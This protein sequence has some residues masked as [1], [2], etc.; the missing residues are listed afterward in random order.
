MRRREFLGGTVSGAVATAAMVGAG[1]TLVSHLKDPAE[2]GR[3]SYSEQ[4]EDL[5]LFHVVRDILRAETA[6]Y[7]DVGAAYPVKGNNTY[8]LYSAGGEGVLVEPNPALA[9]QLR[10]RRP[11]DQVVEAGVGPGEATEA[12]YFVV[13]GN[14]MLNTF[15]RA[16]V[17]ELGRERGVDAVARVLKMPLVT[18]NR[19]IAERFRAAPD[20]LSTDVEGLDFDILQTL[21]LEHRR[22][23]AICAESAWTTREGAHS[24]IA[25][26][27]IAKGY[28]P[29]GGSLVNTIFVDGTRG[30]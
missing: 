28:V 8:L 29:R 14:D 10:A 17:D 18:L 20:V 11:R 23:G 4:G 12:D 5:V 22:P 19:L 16:R 13:K 25:A 3:T 27:L 21:D 9:A 26:Y 2:Q 15:S 1:T 7:L 6:T 30:R 24:P